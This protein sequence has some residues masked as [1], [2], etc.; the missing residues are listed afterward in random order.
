MA[1]KHMWW[2]VYTK[3]TIYN[4]KGVFGV[5]TF[6]QLSYLHVTNSP[7]ILAWGI[8]SLGFGSR[9]L[10]LNPD[11]PYSRGTRLDLVAPYLDLNLDDNR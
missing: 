6:P 5:C 7:Q 3:L 11:P 2:L 9:S 4:R 8:I 1:I 10:D